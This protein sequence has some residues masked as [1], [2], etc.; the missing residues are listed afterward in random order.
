MIGEPP[1]AETEGAVH[2][3]PLAVRPRWRSASVMRCSTSG[4]A[5]AP[6]RLRMPTMPHIA[7]ASGGQLVDRVDDLLVVAFAHCVVQ[8][9]GEGVLIA[10]TRHRER[11]GA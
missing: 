10:G 3:L 9:K 7:R 5:G 2:E 4:G 8:R 11:I 6:S 1:V